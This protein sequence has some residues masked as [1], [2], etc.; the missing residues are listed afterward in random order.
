L[1]DSPNASWDLFG[2]QW[3]Q[4]L[5]G[6]ALDTDGADDELLPPK[7]RYADFLPRDWQQRAEKRQQRLLGELDALDGDVDAALLRDVPEQA[8]VE[9]DVGPRIS[10]Q[11]MIHAPRTTRAGAESPRML[12]GAPWLNDF[13]G[14]KY[15][16]DQDLGRATGLRISL[17]RS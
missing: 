16:E 14:T 11:S 2:S 13:L 6:A 4:L 15:D 7:Q 5:A 8:N 10:W 17:P 1:P 12:D 3:E 9:R